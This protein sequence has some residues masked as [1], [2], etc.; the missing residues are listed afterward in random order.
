MNK[1]YMKYDL[2]SIKICINPEGMINK[3]EHWNN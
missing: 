3:N 2:F 1:T